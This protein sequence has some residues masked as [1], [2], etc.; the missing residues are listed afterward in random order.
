MPAVG[1]ARALA[2]F[3]EQR[4][5]YAGVAF[6][7]AQQQPFEQGGFA[8]AGVADDGDVRTG[9]VEQQF[10]HIALRSLLVAAAVELEFVFAGERAGFLRAEF[11]RG[12]EE[13]DVLPGQFER[14]KIFLHCLRDENFGE[15]DLA[16]EVGAGDVKAIEFEIAE[17]GADT[18]AVF[19]DAEAWIE[20]GEAGKIVAD[21]AQFDVAGDGAQLSVLL[22]DGPHPDEVALGDSIPAEIGRQRGER[23]VAPHAGQASVVERGDFRIERLGQ[24][25]LHSGV[26]Q[27]LGGVRFELRRFRGKKRVIVELIDEQLGEG[28]QQR[29]RE[30][31]LVGWRELLKRVA[32]Q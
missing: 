14:R 23:E 6:C 30:L 32:E 24:P 12:L 28:C 22:D 15:L 13:S 18:V 16:R 8:R 31:F 5:R 21:F 7:P 20:A 4:E 29:F 11:A 2:Q 1:L 17:A 10:A 26:F 27:E 3:D 19:G 25:A 9:G